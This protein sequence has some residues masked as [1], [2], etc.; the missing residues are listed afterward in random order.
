[1]NTPADNDTPGS[2]ALDMAAMKAEAQDFAATFE[3]V[4]AEIGKLI[5]GQ[6]R[7]I[8]R[9]SCRERVSSKV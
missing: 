5:V 2:P 7:E 6:A 1:M 4:R 8:G 9:A 3:A